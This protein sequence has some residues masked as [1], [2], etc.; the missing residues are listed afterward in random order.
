MKIVK[1]TLIV[2]VLL[3][4]TMVSAQSQTVKEIYKDKDGKVLT[5]EEAGKIM[6]GGS[7]D[8]STKILGNGDVE[9]I[10]S[11]IKRFS[12]AETL[13]MLTE[14]ENW[15]KTLIGKSFPDF[16]R[17][18]LDGKTINKSYLKGK[19]AVFNFWF[20]ACKPCVEEMPDLNKLVSKYTKNEV[21][22][23]APSIDSKVAIQKFLENHS[24]DYAVTT[25][26][27]LLADKLEIKG[28]PTHFV[29]DQAGVIRAVFVGGSDRIESLLS[30]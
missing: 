24:F 4:Q 30:K 16:E 1:T 19:V 26:S 15:R 3:F 13:A 20:V 25:D 27:R 12:E 6:N 17:T 23:I 9:I 10:L 28:Y 29:V 2:L 18:S 5:E 21:A 8:M 11:Q 22:F 7:Y 14:D